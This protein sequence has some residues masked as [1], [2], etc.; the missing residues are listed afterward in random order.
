MLIIF[1]HETLGSIL[2]N[3]IVRHGFLKHFVK[4]IKEA[5]IGP[6]LHIFQSS[7]IQIIVI[8]IDILAVG[9]C[10][11]CYILHEVANLTKNILA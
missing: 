3:S 4:P 9:V 5:Q 10:F 2:V 7:Y 1:E 6:T 11:D 8:R